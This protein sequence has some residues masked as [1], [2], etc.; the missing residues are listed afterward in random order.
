MKINWSK[1]FPMVADDINDISDKIEY[2]G[3]DEA[4]E[5]ICMKYLPAINEYFRESDRFYRDKNFDRS[6]EALKNAYDLAGEITEEKGQQCSLFFQATVI[7]SLENIHNE[8]DRMSR[9]LFAT[10]KYQPQ[11]ENADRLLKRIR[12]TKEV[13][14]TYTTVKSSEVLQPAYL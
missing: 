4:I 7:Q 3:N 5:K 10:R 8:L 2:T 1:I 11:F 14:N 13:T 6:I 9:G 12:K